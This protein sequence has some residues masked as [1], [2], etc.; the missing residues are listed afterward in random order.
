[1]L[2]LL[3]Q[4]GGVGLALRIFVVCLVMGLV[5]VLLIGLRCAECLPLQLSQKQLTIAF[6]VAAFST[7]AAQVFSEFPTGD[8]KALLRLGLATSI[9]TGLPAMIVVAG[10]TLNKSM[11]T[12]EMICILM[13]FY[14]IGLF[15]SLYLDIGRL[16]RQI[17]LRGNVQ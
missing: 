16:N 4:S 9:R 12:I 13:L 5:L 6:F 15:A 2:R 10:A 14:G 11:M 8:D 17:H 1:M 3:F 7:A